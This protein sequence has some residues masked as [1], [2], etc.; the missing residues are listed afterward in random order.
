MKLGLNKNKIVKKDADSYV[1]IKM[2]FICAVKE[3]RG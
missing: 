2:N 3:R 1:V